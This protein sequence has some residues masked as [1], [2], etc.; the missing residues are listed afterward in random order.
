METD[1]GKIK[2][3]GVISEVNETLT[4]T[5]TRAVGTEDT[6]TTKR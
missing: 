2:E 3:D 5:A 1:T 4:H 6:R